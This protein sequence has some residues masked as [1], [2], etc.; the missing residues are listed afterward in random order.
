MWIRW[1]SGSTLL[2]GTS[3]VLSVFILQYFTSTRWACLCSGR[4][5]LGWRTLEAGGVAMAGAECSLIPPCPPPLDNGYREWVL[6]TLFGGTTK[7]ASGQLQVSL[8]LSGKR[9]GKIYFESKA[10]CAANVHGG[11]TCPKSAF[12]D[13][14]VEDSASNLNVVALW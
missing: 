8:C 12:S 3:V 6:G 13:N 1:V 9:R 11:E 2:Q 10:I 5:W 4:S 7:I 14:F